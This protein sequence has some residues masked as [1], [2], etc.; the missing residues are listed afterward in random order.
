MI[1]PHNP[2]QSTYIFSVWR[3]TTFLGMPN[4]VEVVFVQLPDKA[5]EVAVL[6]M[7]R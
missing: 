3:I 4:F 1:Y 7:L 2:F 6:E 5:C